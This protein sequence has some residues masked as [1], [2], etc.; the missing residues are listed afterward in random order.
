MASLGEPNHLT[1][2]VVSSGCDH[3]LSFSGSLPI[4]TRHYSKLLPKRSSASSSESDFHFANTLIFSVIIHGAL[5]EMNVCACY[6]STCDNAAV[7]SSE[8]QVFCII[9][10]AH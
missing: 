2:Q 7:E 6:T 10:K 1:T 5:K 4:S 9:L 3:V 8:Y